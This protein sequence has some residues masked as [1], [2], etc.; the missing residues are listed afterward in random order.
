MIID[1]EF[2]GLNIRSTHV[3]RF[4]DRRYS[5]IRQSMTLRSNSCLRIT[6]TR[7]TEPTIR[8][9]LSSS[10]HWARWRF[11]AFRH[12]VRY[13]CE[14]SKIGSR[15]LKQN[16]DIPIWKQINRG[17]LILLLLQF[18]RSQIHRISPQ[19]ERFPL[20]LVVDGIDLSFVETK[21][22]KR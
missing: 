10:H 11:L 8:R 5:A 14:V 21:L 17:N 4:D 1:R 22:W 13:R 15:D 19:N 3:D 7:F 12:D 18:Y 16:L 2:F 6:V 9:W 20:N